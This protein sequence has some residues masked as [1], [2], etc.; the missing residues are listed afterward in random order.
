MAKPRMMGP[1]GIQPRAEPGI[2]MSHKS[3]AN[4]VYIRALGFIGT[5]AGGFGVSEFSLDF[6]LATLGLSTESAGGD[7]GA[8]IVASS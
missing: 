5:P 2:K 8:V 7:T 3:I 4:C 6:S 1:I